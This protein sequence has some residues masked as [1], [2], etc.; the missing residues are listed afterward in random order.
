MCAEISRD[1]K[2]EEVNEALKQMHPNKAF[3]PNGLLSL[4]YQWY[5]HIIGPIVTASILHAL[6]SGKIPHAFNPTLLILIPKKNPPLKVTEY[7][8]IS[9]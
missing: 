2:A 1:F 3:G 5:W 7:R 6:N 8:P 9:L 4:F